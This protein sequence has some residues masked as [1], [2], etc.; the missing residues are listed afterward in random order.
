VDPGERD[1]NN[2][3]DD[4]TVSSSS[5][6]GSSSSSGPVSSSGGVEQHSSSHRV[7]EE[8]LDLDGDGFPDKETTISGGCAGCSSS[9]M[10]DA[11]PPAGIL[12]LALWLAGRRWLGRSPG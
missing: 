10:G 6:G 3:A 2:A 1:P 11:L 4:N 12:L 7:N 8:F 9:G 5:G